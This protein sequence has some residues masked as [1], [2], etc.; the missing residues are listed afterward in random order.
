MLWKADPAVEAARKL[1]GWAEF[2]RACG[3][4][5]LYFDHVTR[6]R[7]GFVCDAFTGS[8]TETRKLVTGRGATVI[9]AIADA[10]DRS[11]RANPETRRL[12]AAMTAP[13]PASDFDGLLGGG[14]DF[15]ELL[16]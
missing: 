15:E 4:L 13:I 6:D 16:K 10:H 12:L 11:G 7:T 2:H 3:R 8:G 9:A 14:N 5:T 1:P